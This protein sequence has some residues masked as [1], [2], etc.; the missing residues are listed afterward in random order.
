M[1]KYE[2][3]NTKLTCKTYCNSRR[4][5]SPTLMPSTASITALITCGDV[6]KTLGHT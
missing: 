5:P 6:S 3:A 2:Y 4:G 1:N